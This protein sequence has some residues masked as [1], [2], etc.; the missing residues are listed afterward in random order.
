MPLSSALLLPGAR[1]A[2]CLRCSLDQ[3]H[4]RASHERRIYHLMDDLYRDYILEHYKRPRNFGELEPHDLEAHDHN[5]LCGDEMGV[6]VRVE[7]GRIA[8]L[9][10]HGQGCAISQAS[11]SIAS[12]EYVG[13]PLEE[14][15]ELD[16]EWLIDLLG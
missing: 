2:L 7:D 4:R 8:E 9:R 6:H 12:E 10:F 3:P 15:A 1:A 14:V 11:A 16:G 13:M 5:P